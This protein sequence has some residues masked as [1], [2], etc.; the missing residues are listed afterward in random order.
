LQRPDEIG[1]ADELICLLDRTWLMALIKD[2][3]LVNVRSRD[4]D[5]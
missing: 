4:I 1:S 3:R 2:G 5:R